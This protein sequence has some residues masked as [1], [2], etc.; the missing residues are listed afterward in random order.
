MSQNQM[1]EIEFVL[2]NFEKSTYAVHVFGQ[3]LHVMKYR[4][5]ELEFEQ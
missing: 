1:Q 3:K 5:T 4:S 2:I